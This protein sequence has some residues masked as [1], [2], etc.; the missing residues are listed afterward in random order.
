MHQTLPSPSPSLRGRGVVALL[1]CIVLAVASPAR[2]GAQLSWSTIDA[3]GG[4]SFAD[5]LTLGGTIGQWDAG[6]STGAGVTLIGG[7][8][9]SVDPCRGFC[10]ADCNCDGVVDFFDIDP[11][12]LALSA[13]SQWVV[14]YPNCDLNCNCDVD[15]NGYIDF[16]DIDPFVALLGAECP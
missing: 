6:V 8:W 13:P 12:V 7:F 14:R 11:F 16:F 5:E 15:R 9:A 4:F 3:G 1:F 2:G 10:A